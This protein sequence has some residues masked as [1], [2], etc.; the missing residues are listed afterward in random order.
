[1]LCADETKKEKEMT[2]RSV[3]II[4][5]VVVV[6]V[7]VYRKY[8]RYPTYTWTNIDHLTNTVKF[9]F[10]KKPYKYTLGEPPMILESRGYTLEVSSLQYSIEMSLQK[11]LEEIS[12]ESVRVS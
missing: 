1:M 3:I 4:T 6:A 10:D 7:L 2:R 9:L 12:H 11:D 8:F 5:V